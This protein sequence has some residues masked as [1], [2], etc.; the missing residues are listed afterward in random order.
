MEDKVR[1]K[2]LKSLLGFFE[3]FGRVKVLYYWSH[4]ILQGQQVSPMAFTSFQDRGLKLLP[5][6]ERGGTLTK[7]PIRLT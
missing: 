4:A 3:K 6:D 5:P 7:Q 1:I 2:K